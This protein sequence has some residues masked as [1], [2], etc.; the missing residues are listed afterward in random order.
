MGG[1]DTLTTK[2][3]YR[4]LSAQW[5]FERTVL[6]FKWFIFRYYASSTSHEKINRITVDYG[7]IL[8]TAIEDNHGSQ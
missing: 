4:S 6:W 7:A 5:L 1:H 3:T 2:S 8:L